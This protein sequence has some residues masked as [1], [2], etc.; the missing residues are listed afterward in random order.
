VLAKVDLVSFRRRPAPSKVSISEK[1]SLIFGVFCFFLDKIDFLDQTV[2]F[3]L[4]HVLHILKASALTVHLGYKETFLS[5]LRGV[6]CLLTQ[7][8]SGAYVNSIL[9]CYSRCS[10][11]R[12]V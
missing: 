11:S 10:I 1:L 7:C 12:K 6:A 3:C 4:Y 9:P 2:N 5:I 8:T